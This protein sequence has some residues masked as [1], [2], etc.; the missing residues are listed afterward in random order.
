MCLGLGIEAARKVGRIR[1]GVARA[2]PGVF[3]VI[4]VYTAGGEDSA[5]DTLQGAAVGQ[6]ERADDI[7]P[8]GVLLVVLTPVDVGAAC[9]AGGVKD[10][11]GLDTVELL[12]DLLAVLHA[13]GGGVDV[14]ALLLEHIPQVAGDPAL[15]SPDEEAVVGLGAICSVGNPIGGPVG[16]HLVYLCVSRGGVADALVHPDVCRRGGEGL[17]VQ[18]SGVYR[19]GFGGLRGRIGI[20]RFAGVGKGITIRSEKSKKGHEENRN[21]GGRG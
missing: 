11:G 18:R 7:G 13:N 8:Y 14:L 9:A 4:L 20:V 2:I 12:H 5:V 1:L 10:M 6:V 19:I 16:S 15:T 21:E 3:L 17:R